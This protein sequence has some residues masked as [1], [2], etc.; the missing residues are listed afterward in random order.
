MRHNRH[1]G[2][3][4]DVGARVAATRKGLAPTP[5]PG[6]L[7]ASGA[8]PA[9]ALGGRGFWLRASL[10]GSPLPTY[11]L[12]GRAATSNDSPS[13]AGVA[14]GQDGRR[15]AHALFRSPQTARGAGPRKL[16][17]PSRR[18]FS[19]PLAER[20]SFPPAGRRG[21]A[22]KELERTVG[23]WSR[24][25]AV[26]LPV[27]PGWQLLSNFGAYVNRPL[28]CTTVPA[29][30]PRRSWIQSLHSCTWPFPMALCVIHFFN[31]VQPPVCE[32][33]CKLHLRQEGETL[34]H[35]SL[36]SLTLH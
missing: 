9:R 34:Q 31:V 3:G 8:Q 16:G 27:L 2:G 22:R 26:L 4:G 19:R 5:P 14:R 6:L 21:A 23:L 30:S 28:H 29:R 33:S 12:R 17:G 7:P 32:G 20:G 24:A 36:K 10:L 35:L 11:P 1:A 15:P 18:L 25:G 13:D